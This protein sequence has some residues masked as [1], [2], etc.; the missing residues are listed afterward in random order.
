MA[1]SA[2][3]VCLLYLLSFAGFGRQGCCMA[4]INNAGYA[5]NASYGK[6]PAYL[7][8]L[9]QLLHTAQLTPFQLKLISI[10]D[11]ALHKGMI[12]DFTITALT[13]ESIRILTPYAQKMHAA[14][15]ES[16][17]GL[18]PI[19]IRDMRSGYLFIGVLLLCFTCMLVL[20]AIP[21][22]RNNTLRRRLEAAAV[23]QND[24]NRKYESG[25]QTIADLKEKLKEKQ[26]DLVSGATRLASLQ[27]NIE[28]MISI[29]NSDDSASLEKVQKQLQK[30]VKQKDY[31]LTYEDKFNEAHPYFKTAL[32][33]QYPQLNNAEIFFCSLLKL[34][35]SYKDIGR[36]MQISPDSVVKKKYRTK[37]KMGIE[38][39]EEFDAVLQTI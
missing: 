35:L 12:P 38:N 23:L 6:S 33:K 7:P 8:F 32:S 21:W 27:D 2:P 15:D 37:K 20:S 1:K 24:L 36:I 11:G 25:Q 10:Q 3:L 26:A 39:E 16:R 14:I 34:K 29:C 5:V 17:H 22:I 18:A 4:A 28:E 13:Q 9:H 19:I 31:W 30:L